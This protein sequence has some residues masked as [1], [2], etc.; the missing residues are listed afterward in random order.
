[1]AKVQEEWVTVAVDVP[2]SRVRMLWEVLEGEG[3]NLRIFTSKEQPHGHQVNSFHATVT[4]D[5]ERKPAPY[6]LQFWTEIQAIFAAA[7]DRTMR[8]DDPALRNVMIKHERSPNGLTPVLSDF[9][10]RGWL[11]KAQRGWWRM[12]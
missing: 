12:P 3:R 11:V 6:A 2:R 5:K 4:P 7:P 1:M 8:Y 10:K 9:G